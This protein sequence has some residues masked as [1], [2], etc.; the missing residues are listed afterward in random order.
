MMA[1][2]DTYGVS[3]MPEK[4]LVDEKGHQPLSPWLH[5]VPL[6]GQKETLRV[7]ALDSRIIFRDK[8]EQE[9]ILSHKS[10][11]TERIMTHTNGALLSRAGRCRW[12]VE[13]EC[14]N[15]LKNQGYH[16]EHNYGHGSN[17]LCVNFYLF[18]LLAL[19]VHQVFALT[20]G[21]YQAC[22]QKLGR[23]PHRWETLRSSLKIL[24][25]D[26][27]DHLRDFAYTPSKDHVSFQ[28]P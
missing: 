5:D 13:N 17:H 11:V 7:N 24:V 6:N 9:S 20:D 25:F 27:W 2:L 21:L 22:R 26:P 3:R 8:D 28:P 12:K 10:W 16:I 18:T 23:K 19:Y 14:F 15:T 1:W 4:P